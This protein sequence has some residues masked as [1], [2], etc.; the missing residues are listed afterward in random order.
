[1]LG[2]RFTFLPLKIT[3]AIFLLKLFLALLFG[4]KKLSVLIIT[5]IMTLV[6]SATFLQ[7]WKR[8]QVTTYTAYL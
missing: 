7:Q 4:G 3:S 2:S 8:Q 6:Q 5:A 1:M